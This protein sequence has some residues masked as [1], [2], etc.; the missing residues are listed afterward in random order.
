MSKLSEAQDLVN[1]AR[2]HAARDDD[3]TKN[4]VEA[5]QLI[6]TELRGAE[7]GPDART[8]SKTVRRTHEQ[9]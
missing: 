7:Q 1:N 6:L 9:K 4:L 2:Q 3:A 8:S 5:V